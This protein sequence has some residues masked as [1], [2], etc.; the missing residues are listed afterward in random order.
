MIHLRYVLATITKGTLVFKNILFKNSYN[1]IHV[2]KHFL[3]IK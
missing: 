3:G 2:C 1:N